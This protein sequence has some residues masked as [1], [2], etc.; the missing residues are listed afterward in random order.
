LPRGL[1]PSTYLPGIMYYSDTHLQMVGVD[2]SFQQQQRGGLGS[3]PVGLT[4]SGGVHRSDGAT[5]KEGVLHVYTSF[6]CERKK[7]EDY[8]EWA[9]PTRRHWLIQ[10]VVGDCKGAHAKEDAKEEKYDDIVTGGTT[11]RVV[12]ELGGVGPV[13]KLIPCRILRNAGPGSQ[14]AVWFRPLNG[15]DADTDGIIGM[16]EANEDGGKAS[17][18]QFMEG[19]ELVFL[20]HQLMGDD[21]GTPIPQALVVS[22]NGGSVA[23][24]VHTLDPA[25]KTNWTQ[26][27]GTA[28]RPILGVDATSEE[29]YVECRRLILTRFQEQVGLLAVGT[30]ASGKSCLIAGTLESDQGLVWSNILPNIKE[31]PVLWLQDDEQVSLLVPLPWERTIRGGLA[32]A[33]TQRV[34]IISP[35]LKILAQVQVSLP[36]S[37]LVPLGSYTVAY[38]SHDD[39]KIR[40]LSGLP[41]SFG[42]SGL[43]AALPLPQ[44]SYNPHWLLAVRP[45][46]FIYSPW[47]TGTRLVD[48]GQNSN[49]FLLPTAITR[50]ALLLEPMIANAIATGGK[51]TATQTFFRTVVEKFGRKVQTMT[52]G[53]GEGI[54]NYGAGMTPRAFE[55]LNHYNL[56]AAASWLLTG[57]THFDR[58]ANSRLMPAWMPVTAKIKAAIDAD[59][60]LHV[61]A[62]GDQYFTEYVKSPDHNMSATLPRPS[63]PSAF[64]CKEFAMDALKN[65]RTADALKMLDIVG[66]ES[67][68]SM[69]L[70][71]ALAM[72]IDPFKDVTPVLEALCQQESQSGK[73]G[74]SA[75]AASLAALALELR[76]KQ[77]PDGDF[78]KRWMKPLAPSL[79]RGNRTGRLRARIMGEAA[80]SKVGKVEQVK[81]KLFSTE[82]SESKHVWNEG[83]NREKENLLMLDHIQEWF[84]RRRPVILGKEGAK[85]ADDR[86]ASTL[87]DILAQPDDDSFGGDE[88]DEAEDG[89]VDGIGEGQ[90]DE[91]KLSAYYR[92]SEGEDEDTSWREEGFA[93]ISKYEVKAI[94]VGCN[95]TAVLQSSTSSVDEGDPGK[96]KAIF[97]LVFEQTGIGLANA[98]A[99]PASRGGSLDVGM[100]HGPEHLSRQ[101]CSV[102]F[103]FWVPEAIKR[104]MILVRR[105]F[106]SSADDLENVCK[107]SDKSSSLWELALSSKGELEFRTIAGG[108]IRSE[109]KPPNDD[110][111]EDE[112]P[113]S[114][115]QFSRWNHVCITFKQESITSSAVDV[116]VK[117]L[118][119][120]SKTLSFAPPDFEVDDFQGASALDPILEKSHLVFGL[121]HPASFRL[122]EMR[123]WAVERADDDTRAMMTEHLEC[124]EMKR[125]FRVKIKKKGG[126]G[127]KLGGLAPAKAGLAPPGGLAAPKITLG[128]PKGGLAPPKG[129]LAPPGARKGLLAPPKHGKDDDNE[130]LVSPKGD[131][132]F[133]FGGGDAMPSTEDSGFGGDGFGSFG[134]KPAKDTTPVSFDTG[135]GDAGAF[136]AEPSEFQPV[137]GSEGEPDVVEEPEISPL[138]DSA[139]PLSEQV[140]SSAAAALIRGPPATR[141]FG[142]NRGGLP[143]Y[144]EL[145]RFGVGAISICGSEK[146]IVWRD[147]QVPPGLTYPIGASGAI[148]S[149]QMDEDG[150]EF[151][152]CFLAKD[153]RMVVFELSTRTVVVE[154]QMTTKLNYWRFLPPEAGEDTLCFMLVTPVGGFHW[155][156]LD[157]SPRPRQVWKRGPELQVSRCYVAVQCFCSK[158]RSIVSL[159]LFDYRERR[160]YVTKKVARTDWTV[161]ICCQR[162]ACCSLRMLQQVAAWKRGLYQS[163]EIL[164]RFALL[165]TCWEP[166]FAVLQ[167]LVTKPGCHYCSLWWSQ[168][169]ILSSVY[170]P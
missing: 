6:Q 56:K 84:G 91:D 87:A 5:D 133:G 150:S 115:I 162:L 13:S 33:T 74:G 41:D 106:G 1:I 145:E 98:L 12:C 90:K 125:K 118:S 142:G 97:D 113:K 30:K 166:V 7:K 26:S 104:E 140:R 153:K 85:S 21:A 19:R 86:G 63:D 112:G 152:C 64:L 68:D 102:E 45:D 116:F 14:T 114:T 124:A 129:G 111:E 109:L 96:V 78:T 44:Y 107:A 29:D 54:G 57:T 132:G 8:L 143:D 130:K 137:A 22:R 110:D 70:Q 121:D 141:H 95:D 149:D 16:I 2:Q 144:R 23:L 160:L 151:L 37:S 49:S 89:W 100:M 123:V 72:Q 42:R 25:T 58:S 20:P 108:K 119:E 32:V 17:L 92:F 24:W 52:H 161:Q 31:D 59:T 48:R 27:V 51:D 61:I 47:H 136:E 154:L 62:Y 167:M 93:D 65:G 34:M 155:M 28:C 163:V 122:T 3:V 80:F 83:P 139:I 81:D 127:G 164:R 117:G 168:K 126:D 101:K 73:A 15:D 60:N 135:F 159:F 131:S 146:T 170:L 82:T 148:V 53:E 66:T 36:P 79:Q 128:P 169:V 105:T 50:P 10:T 94:L 103:W 35:D 38:C 75:T 138:W 76:K 165:M 11:S 120:C 4:T 43:I 88:E 69:I 18:G 134:G 67:S 147:D 156:P 9:A 157:E 46:R 55:L 77:I 40:Y 71:L 158:R 99:I 39:Y